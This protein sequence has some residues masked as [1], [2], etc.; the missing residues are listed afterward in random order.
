MKRFLICVL[1][2]TFLLSFTACGDTSNNSET[3]APTD[4]V[5]NESDNEVENYSEPSQG[6]SIDVDKN[7]FD[8]EITI[9]ADFIGEDATQESLEESI[10]D[11]E[12]IKS[13]VLNADG[14]A[15]YTMTKAA[16]AE[17]LDSIKASIDE[18]LTDMV[19]DTDYSF[20]AIEHN[21]NYTEFTV[22]TDAEEVGMADS[23]SVLTFYMYGGMYAAFSGN[24]V[25][26]IQVNFVNSSSGEIIETANS[27]EMSE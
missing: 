7:L 15:T 19:N 20:T 23:F 10:A 25:D 16:H 17:L 6:G 21:G 24:T 11:N 9:P 27:S 8:V 22:K 2:A 14:S 1:C 3:G 4:S 12:G 5:N 18:G 13:V 26:N